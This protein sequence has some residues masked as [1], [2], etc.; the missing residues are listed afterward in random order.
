MSTD[1]TVIILQTALSKA[2]INVNPK[3]VELILL[4]HPL[5]PS[6][7]S[8]C[9]TLSQ[10]GI[11]HY[12]LKLKDDEVQQLAD[13][14]IA[15][16]NVSGGQLAFVETVRGNTVHLRLGQGKID[17]VSFS[18]FAQKFSGAVVLIEPKQPVKEHDSVHTI[19]AEWLKK[20]LVPLSIAIIL[21]LI[22]TIILG[23]NSGIGVSSTLYYLLLTKG[24]GITLSV[25]LVLH[26]MKVYVPF[27][28]KLCNL[29]P[30]SD[31]SS[32]LSSKASQLVG[33]IGLADVGLIYFVAT[34]TYLVSVM[35]GGSPWPL[36]AISLL[37]LGA[38]MYTIPAQLRMGRW[39]PLCLSVMLVLIAEFMLLA[40]SLRLTTFSVTDVF[41][42]LLSITA[43]LT[44]WLL[45][46]HLHHT[47]KALH[48][49]QNIYYALKR[50]PAVLLALMGQRYYGPLPPVGDGLKYGNQQAPV[51]V[52]AFM[53]LRCKHCAKAFAELRELITNNPEI[54]VSV[55]LAPPAS[56][57][58]Q[59]I[60][61]HIYTQHHEQGANASMDFL[62]SWYSN[63]NGA[64][65]A[66]I[67]Q[68]KQNTKKVDITSWLE[69]NRKLF[70][71]CHVAGTP[72]ILA[73]GFEYPQQYGINEIHH[74]IPQI[75]SLTQR[76]K[77]Q[78]AQ[79]VAHL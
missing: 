1:N 59:V 76:R 44:L 54:C 10:L 42:V 38:P 40:P 63:P 4:T 21:L 67:S 3:R 11:K 57:E 62:A 79:T 28:E 13:P 6:L 58:Q 75:L 46:K 18:S 49:Q 27:T 32:V 2:K 31:C 16:L 5:Y 53:S 66:V 60:L 45:Y 73:N 52:K 35:S 64:T 36:A 26:E 51:E 19:A 30:R 33:P 71:H 23:K 68:D 43:P 7:K 50:Q 70:E 69:Q 9:D 47:A 8:V 15:H 48:Q 14:F 39:C 22:T 29:A 34:L 20:A 24:L 17:H 56:D 12:A 74:Y 37:A 65:Q 61:A 77:G 78:E 41:M 25:L 72:T 55:V